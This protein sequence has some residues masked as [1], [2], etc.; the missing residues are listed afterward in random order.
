VYV[1][2]DDEDWGC[3]CELPGDVCVHV[4]AAVIAGRKVAAS[5]NGGKEA[6]PKPKATYAVTLRYTFKSQK[7]NLTVARDLVYA[8]GRTRALKGTLADEDVLVGRSDAQAE[9]LLALHPG[10]ALPGETLRRLLYILEGDA[11]ATLDGQPVNLSRE[12]LSFEV[13]VTDAGE[14]FKVG[15]YRPPGIERLFRGA[16][17]HEGRL[18]P[19]SHGDLTRDQRRMLLQ[20]VTF[21]TDEVARLVSDYLPRLRERI[22]VRIATDRLP[23][24]DDLK[25]RVQLLM[26]ELPDGLSVE[27]RLVYGDPPVA[28]ITPGGALERISGAVVAG[29]DL[30]AERTAVRRF[31]ARLGLSVGYRQTLRPEDAAAFLLRKLP[32]H[33][34]P[35]VGQVD[36]DR[37]RI[38]TR[39]VVPRIDVRQSDD[40]WFLDVGFATAAEGESGESLAADPYTVLQA[41]RSN[42]SMVPLMEGGYA[43][44]PVDWLKEHGALL[45]ELLD[46]RDATGKVQRSATAALVE[47]L[48][49]TEG[50]VPPD[51]K[52]LREWLEGGDGLPDVPIPSGLH[53]DL[54]PY[55]RAG[56]QWMRFLRDMD[57]S[58]VLADD[59]GLGKTVQALAAIL[60][61]G[62]RSIVVAPTSVVSNWVSEANRFAPGLSVNLYHG[63]QRTLD[64]SDLTITT[65]ALLRLDLDQLAEQ[66]WTYAIL[67]EAQAIKN[68][69][70]QTARAACKLPARHRLALTGTPVENRLEELWSL[71]R[72]LMPGLLGS[73]ES[74][75][76]RFVRPIESGS[77]PARKALRAR[78][79][80]YVLRRLKKQVATEL[81]PLTEQVLRCEM[82]TDQRKLYDTVR[83][84]ARDDVQQALADK[85]A[86]GAA[87]QVL[88]A[89]LRMR[90]AC[91]DPAL[92][93]GDLGDGVASAKLDR[94]EDLLVEVVLEE[95]KALVFSQW[96]GLLDR[97]ELRLKKLGIDW[98]RLD[99]S[100]RDRQSLIDRFQSDEGPPVFL[101]SLKAGGTGLNLTAADYVVHLDPWW[102]PAV[103]QQ[104]T[105]RAHRIGQDKPV[106]SYK[107]IAEGTVEE[108]ILELQAS[109][110]DLAEA[111]IGAE[112]GFLK[113]LS[114]N[115]LRALFDESL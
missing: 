5:G 42:R 75:K 86:R 72:Y 38:D 99:G 90:Q 87:F 112:G 66:D 23:E 2:P 27:P 115:E 47:L 39:E 30:A 81:P 102:N 94:L 98:V 49:E 35:V 3:D 111:A 58:G 84:A 40:G 6:L 44:L 33:D 70:S 57:L 24:D 96:T 29:R 56:L 16:A 106:V 37:F 59:M 19:T 80:P 9:S 18:R 62:G 1:W 11:K 110:R 53:A 68:P 82:G 74:F 46:G 73:L 55:Q 113:S 88:E 114:A 63:P 52:R 43:P 8:D 26:R 64:D 12:P 10:G 103:E 61:S 79:R 97:A 32:Q 51:L 83:L 28:R 67:D 100:T 17:L 71:F 91:C 13:R 95:H 22:P 92:L 107:L 14:G 60:D 31:E 7:T 108:R 76:E 93:P 34:G 85:G 65:Y 101:L 105:D 78:V 104:A 45:R 89:L 41:W 20:G 25:P 69:T 50:T 48:E 109:K 15:L 4:A 21:S 77:L 36:P 54:R